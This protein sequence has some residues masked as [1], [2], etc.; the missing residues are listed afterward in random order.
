[1]KRFYEAQAFEVGQVYAL[2]S[3]NS[4]H[5]KNV[6]RMNVG[7]DLI[8]F[9]GEPR[10]YFATLS[11]ISKKL[12]QVRI[13]HIEDVHA[14]S[15][16]DL[17]L[18]QGIAR[19]DKMDWI[20]QKAVELGVKGIYPLMTEFSL[21]I[22]HERVEKKLS[23]W[24]AIAVNACEQSGR[25][26]IPEIHP[27]LTLYEMISKNTIVPAF[28][29]TPC[30]KTQSNLVWTEKYQHSLLIIGPEGGLSEKEISY[31]HK[32]GCVALNLGPRVLRTETATVAALSVMQFCFG[33]LCGGNAR[34][35][36]SNK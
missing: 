29:L 16:L 23:H 33:D 21:A 6:L 8:L 22:P 3:I 34:C 26:V 30:A 35:I 18:A 25:T 13:D 9:N 12:V 14:E 19:G 17:Y 36:D 4:H 1:M 32:N 15:P 5:V 24:R 28:V 31:A 27:P 20:V 7:N 11:H 2:N 10:E